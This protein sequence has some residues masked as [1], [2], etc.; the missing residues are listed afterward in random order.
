MQTIEINWKCYGSN[1]QKNKKLFD[2][3]KCFVCFSRW[4]LGWKKRKR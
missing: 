1:C 3:K 2:D 4:N